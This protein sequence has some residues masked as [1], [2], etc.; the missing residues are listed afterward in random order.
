MHRVLDRELGDISRVPGVDEAGEH[1]VDDEGPATRRAWMERG[2]ARDAAARKKTVSS[3]S[4]VRDQAIHMIDTPAPRAM[5]IASGSAGPWK[6]SS[7]N[8]FVIS[9]NCMP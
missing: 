7:M 1:V 5:K 9:V 2:I 8:F 6:W 3:G 4:F